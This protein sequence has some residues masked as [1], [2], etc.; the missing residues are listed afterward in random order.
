MDRTLSVVLGVLVVAALVFAGAVALSAYMGIRYRST[1]SGTYEYQVEITPDALLGNV[2]LYLPVPTRGAESSAVLE[3]IGSGDLGGVPAGWEVS[4]IGTEKFTMLEITARE[5]DPGCGC[6]PLI[7]SLDTKVRGPIRTRTADSEDLVLGTV[8]RVIPAPCVGTDTGASPEMRCWV[9]QGPA[10]ADYTSE[11]NG[12][13]SIHVSLTGR[14]A[15]DVF[16]PSGNEYRDSL[17]FSFSGERQGWRTGDGS[18]VTG[19]GDYWLEDYWLIPERTSG[20]EPAWP[21]DLPWWPLALR[22]AAA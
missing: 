16:G 4:L 22:R 21:R 13:L 11:G 17:Q 9:Y 18:L 10:Y 3:R 12:Q 19:I 5:I 6:A 14:N 1:L 7:L 20:G 15:W 8:T 2:T